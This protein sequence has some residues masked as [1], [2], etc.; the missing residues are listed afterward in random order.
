MGLFPLFGATGITTFTFHNV[1]TG[2][3]CWS[4]CSGPRRQS[5]LVFQVQ[6]RT[7][8]SPV[9]GFLPEPLGPSLQ[10]AATGGA[11]GGP[12]RPVAELTVQRARDVAHFK[13][14]S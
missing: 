6:P 8:P 14:V 3:G 4:T 2:I 11:A 12:R 1:I 10:A 7:R 5:Y 9:E 13:R